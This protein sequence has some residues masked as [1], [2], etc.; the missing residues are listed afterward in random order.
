MRVD[1]QHTV[2]K[3]AAARKFLDSIVKGEK[4]NLFEL[5]TPLDSDSASIV[6]GDSSRALL[7]SLGE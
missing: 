6:E 4:F 2:Q 7:F 5:L 3:K 1:I